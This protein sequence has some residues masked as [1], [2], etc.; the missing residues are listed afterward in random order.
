MPK[1]S[2]YIRI[3]RALPVDEQI[4]LLKTEYWHSLPRGAHL[5]TVIHLAATQL[6]GSMTQGRLLARTKE[7]LSGDWD[8]PHSLQFSDATVRQYI[9]AYILYR[10]G[11]MNDPAIPNHIK[12]HLGALPSKIQAECLVGLLAIYG[13]Q[14]K[15]P[16]TSQRVA[17]RL[18]AVRSVQ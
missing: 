1:L 18:N 16:S 8:S 15:P 5:L 3:P 12:R 4:R 17:L 2:K 13:N 6:T 10:R 14:S 7:H 11:R 9:K